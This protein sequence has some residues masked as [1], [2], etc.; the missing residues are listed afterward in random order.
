MQQHLT[1]NLAHGDIG[2][3]YFNIEEDNNSIDKGN[4]NPDL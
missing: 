1:A 2:L 3:N 4:K